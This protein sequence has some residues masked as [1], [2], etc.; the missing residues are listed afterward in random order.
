[1]KR[2]LG[3]ALIVGVA[4]AASAEPAIQIRNNG[5]LDNRLNVVIV[6]DGYTQS[7]LIKFSTDV[8]LLVA[9]L[10]RQA[11]YSEYERYFNVFRVDVTSN[12]SGVDHPE[13]G[14]LR[15]TALGAAYNCGGIQRTICVNNALVT[16]VV[17]RS[18]PANARDL[19]IVLVNDPEYGGSGGAI[20][21]GSTHQ[22]VVELVLHEAG[23]TLGLLADE[24]TTQPPPCSNGSEPPE[25]NATRATTRESIKWNVWISASTPVPTTTSAS[26]VPGLYQ[27][28]RYCDTGLFRPTFDSKMRSLGRPFEQINEEQLILRFY[29]FV[30]PIESV[31]PSDAEIALSA[32]DSAQFAVETPR[33][34]HALVVRWKLDGAEIATGSSLTLSASQVPGGRHQLQVE[35]SDPTASVRRDPNGLLVDRHEWGL[36]VSASWGRTPR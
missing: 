4:A 22:Q 28:A 26:A 19:I 32:G 21:V 17:N 29:N 5:P 10:F 14:V 20:T 1:V 9:A 12:E 33:A 30:S 31:A 13:R 11:P 35:V 6:G 25:P 2:A 23:H 7:E 34:G 3:A 18:V 24:Y 16:A 27:G 36:V 15:D 8:D